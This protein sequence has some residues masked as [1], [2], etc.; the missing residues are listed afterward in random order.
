[1]ISTVGIVSEVTANSVDHCAAP[2]LP[3]PHSDSWRS[4]ASLLTHDS[5]PTAAPQSA[6]MA[7]PTSSRR[8]SEPSRC[9]LRIKITTVA[10]SAPKKAA[11]I[12]AYNIISAGKETGSTTH[13]ATAQAA[14][15]LIPSNPGSA[16]GLRNSPCI[17]QP[18]SARE[19]PITSASR[20]RGR[21]IV[22]QI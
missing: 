6:L 19:P 2:R 20:T 17:T 14:P 10:A 8:E 9:W 5:T 22:S 7:M 13:R 21:R 15:L 16:S 11:S 1:M 18:A 12:G 4:C 3:I